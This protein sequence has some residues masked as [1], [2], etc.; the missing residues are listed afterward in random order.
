[1]PLTFTALWPWP[2]NPLITTTWLFISGNALH[3]PQ[4]N[5]LPEFFHNN[6]GSMVPRYSQKE[7]SQVQSYLPNLP[8]VYYLSDTNP[9]CQ[10]LPDISSILPSSFQAPIAPSEMRCADW[11][12]ESQSSMTSSFS[13]STSPQL[14]PSFAGQQYPNMF[15]IRMS[16]N[17]P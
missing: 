9:R 5:S 2:C 14:S 16:P 13:V 11:I 4:K 7:S 10:N 17:L 12:T 8:E 6:T 1:M 15:Q 3:P